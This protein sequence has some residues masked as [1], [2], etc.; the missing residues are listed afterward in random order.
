MKVWSPRTSLSSLDSVHMI[1]HGLAT[2]GFPAP[3]VLVNPRPFMA[4]HGAIME[5]CDRGTQLDAHSVP[6]RRQMA[7]SLA[8][9]IALATPF[10]NLPGLPRHDYPANGAFGPAHNVLFDFHA[11]RHGAEWIDEIAIASAHRAQRAPSRRVVGHRDW[12]MHNV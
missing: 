8:Q 4:G 2:Q 10:A 3:R 9:L 6:V 11:T 5:W 1:Q 7:A 12:S